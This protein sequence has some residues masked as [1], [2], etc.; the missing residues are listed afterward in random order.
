MSNYWQMTIAEL[1][2]ESVEPTKKLF[3]F[4]SYMFH[5]PIC[6]EVVGIYRDP[7]FDPVTNGMELQRKECKHGHVIDWTNVKDA[8]P[9][10]EP[11]GKFCDCEWGSLR[12]FY[13]RGYMRDPET[14]KFLRDED[15][16]PIR[17]RKKE[18]DYE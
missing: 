17:A 1:D 18:C 3:Y 10:R 16:R 12:C 5:C 14:K 4:G 6:G 11:C 13:K 8:L 7:K 2:M 15:G 9:L